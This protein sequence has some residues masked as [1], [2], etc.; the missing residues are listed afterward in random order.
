MHSIHLS[1]KA[2]A[3]GKPKPKA[4]ALSDVG[5]AGK[6]VAEKVATLRGE[7]NIV[8]HRVVNFLQSP[9]FKNCLEAL[10]VVRS[11]KSLA[12][13]SLCGSTPATTTSWLIT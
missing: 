10:Q 4:A 11:K 12:S 2:K 1:G 7:L 5:L 6:T 3:K 9:V 13:C 8:F